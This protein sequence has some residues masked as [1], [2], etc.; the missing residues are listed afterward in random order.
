MDSS[1]IIV[2]EEMLASSLTLKDKTPSEEILSSITHYF[3]ELRGLCAKGPVYQVTVAESNIVH[4]A[5]EI[6]SKLIK[7]ALHLEHAL[8]CIRVG[9][10]FIG[11]FVVDNSKNKHY[12]WKHH[13]QLLRQV[14]SLLAMY[15]TVKT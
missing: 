12:I 7:D 9:V 1:D 4:H 14:I 2:L 13:Q 10:Q 5:T 3:R 8:V 15:T 11:N 6:L